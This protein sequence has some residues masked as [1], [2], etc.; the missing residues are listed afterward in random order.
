M[1]YWWCVLQKEVKTFSVSQLFKIDFNSAEIF[2]GFANIVFRIV[3][4]VSALNKL[5]ETKKKK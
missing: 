1:N 2:K 5:S 3:S 4:V